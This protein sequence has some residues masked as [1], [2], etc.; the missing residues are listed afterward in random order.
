M[1]ERTGWNGDHRMSDF[2]A[3]IGLSSLLHFC[4]DHRRDFLQR[5]DTKI[6]KLSSLRKSQPTNVRV[7]PLYMT[8]LLALSETVNGQCFISH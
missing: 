6:R 8:G 5:L 2:L 3:K 7:P 4:E 1:I